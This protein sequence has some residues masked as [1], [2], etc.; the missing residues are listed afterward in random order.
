MKT[1]KE[2][3]AEFLKQYLKFDLDD[4]QKATINQIAELSAAKARK[5]FY[6]TI[7]SYFG[8]G[9]SGC[10]DS[11][12][13]DKNASGA[14]KTWKY[15][16]TRP[17]LFWHEKS[18]YV[19]APFYCNRNIKTAY[20]SLDPI[21]EMQLGNKWFGLSIDDSTTHLPCIA[22]D[23]DRHHCYIC[24][25]MHKNLYKQIRMICKS[26]NQFYLEAEVNPRNGSFKIFMFHRGHSAMPLDIARKYADEIKAN[27]L[28]VTGET[29]EVFGTKANKSL[30][31]PAVRPDK[32][33]IMWSGLISQHTE[34]YYKLPN[35][36]HQH[37]P[38]NDLREYL[39]SKV[40]KKDYDEEAF[41]IELD[42]GLAALP[43][44]SKAQI[45]SEEA[46][47]VL[48]AQAEK[49]AAAIQL[50]IKEQERIANNAK[51]E[52]ALTE[53]RSNTIHNLKFQLRKT[54]GSTNHKDE[55]EIESAFDNALF[56]R[57]TSSKDTIL[58]AAK[59]VA[60]SLK[61]TDIY[62]APA[63]D[64]YSIFKD[65]FPAY[66]KSL[67]ALQPSK[68]SIKSATKP[69]PKHVKAAEELPVAYIASSK[70]AASI[71]A[72]WKPSELEE[73]RNEPDAFSRKQVMCR[74]L[75]RKLRR[76]ASVDEAVSFYEINNLYGGDWCDGEA[77]RRKTFNYILKYIAKTFAPATNHI[78]F[79]PVKRFV[80]FV[81]K[82]F[83]KLDFVAIRK[84]QQNC[85]IN[86]E[87]L[88]VT[89][90]GKEYV[91]NY[92]IT[93]EEFAWY[94]YCLDFCR[95][96]S[97]F[98]DGGGP[99]KRISALFEIAKEDGLMNFT[100][101][102]VKL[103]FVRRF[104]H[105]KNI[106]KCNF[107]KSTGVAYCYKIGSSF[108][109]KLAPKTKRNSKGTKKVSRSNFSSIF[110][111]ASP[112]RNAFTG[113]AGKQVV[114]STLRGS[115]KHSL[116]VTNTNISPTSF[117]SILPPPLLIQ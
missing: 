49:Q 27:I 105:K 26:Y 51:L 10:G 103:N 72:N 41:L 62:K 9:K 64:P 6:E 90:D 89:G 109:K 77:E 101:L 84:S 92:Y 40:I 50:Q 78:D 57:R 63:V 14:K 69:S 80:S 46:A 108:P 31:Y 98:G 70:R 8:N 17:S 99:E 32:K 113:R 88:E 79:Y 21:K 107:K 23:G 39:A 60:D 116:L 24:P 36:K 81:K 13:I 82:R 25:R 106:L 35:G 115:F 66:H 7:N 52:Q 12:I 117:S 34:H 58:E 42:K 93:K 102:P 20:D 2:T 43:Y 114:L 112:Y 5:P 54:K 28:E 67:H 33:Y 68:S 53:I 83:A 1:K 16:Q 65:E 44:K 29:I 11:F 71:I 91:Q 76:V 111:K 56:V 61:I 75:S 48:N 59:Y 96:T 18:S 73:I 87:T 95:K 97:A 4:Q 85:R 38:A 45:Q 110:L 104:L 37:Y 55:T 30:W 22:V 74:L 94:F 100:F 3:K 19:P 86:P 15:S 47:A